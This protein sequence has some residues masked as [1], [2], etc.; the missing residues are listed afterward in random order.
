L[1]ALPLEEFRVP[2]EKS[3]PEQAWA[4]IDATPASMPAPNIMRR[5]RSTLS[6]GRWAEL[7]ALSSALAKALGAGGLFCSFM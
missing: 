4:S 6:A 1:L 7:A 2:E 3:L 5:L